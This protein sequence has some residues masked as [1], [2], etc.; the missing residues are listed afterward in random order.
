LFG[1]LKQIAAQE[2][3][4]F[5]LDGA[6]VDDLSDH[7]PGMRAAREFGVRSPLIQAGL[8]KPEIR[9]LARSL[10]LPLWDKPS[11]ACLASRI[12]YGTRITPPLLA[13]VQTAEDIMRSHGFSV[14]RVRH[15][16]D[17]ARVEVGREEFGRLMSD[18]VARSVTAALR[19]LGYAYV[20]L[21]LEGYRTGSMNEAIKYRSQESGVRSKT[22]IQGVIE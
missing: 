6:N 3:I 17:I 12:P 21:D 8:T 15:H 18:D 16:G 1:V 20:C 19:D 7:R 9:D 10:R 5:I 14:V 4:A 13:K 22:H 2:D 11:M